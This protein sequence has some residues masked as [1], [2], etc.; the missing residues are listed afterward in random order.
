MHPIPLPHMFRI[1]LSGKLQIS[2]FNVITPSLAPV[3]Y[4]PREQPRAVPN[5]GPPSCMRPLHSLTRL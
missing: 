1:I 5:A 4:S 3:P 2:M